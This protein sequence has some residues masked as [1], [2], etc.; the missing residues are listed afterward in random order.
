MSNQFCML[1]ENT[2]GSRIAT[3]NTH[4]LLAFFAGEQG[5]AQW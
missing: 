4:C 5:M 2:D 1:L 3:I